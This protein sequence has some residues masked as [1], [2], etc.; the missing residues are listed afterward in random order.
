[1]LDDL[2]TPAQVSAILGNHVTPRTIQTWCTDGK[3]SATRAGRKWLIRR[4]DLAKFLYP[5]ERQGTES[6]SRA[7]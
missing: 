6:N 7:A 2:L 3:L 5:D 4:R 1:M